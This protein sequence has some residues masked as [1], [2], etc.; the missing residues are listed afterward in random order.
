MSYETYRWGPNGITVDE[1]L[2][3]LRA[4]GW[5]VQD[6]RDY[7][8]GAPALERTWAR[9]PWR[10][11]DGADEHRPC[12]WCGHPGHLCLSYMPTAKCC[13]DYDHREVDGEGE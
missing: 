10:K 7:P 6:T 3:A 5:T 9:S 11:V 12:R 2:E 8:V 4:A 1:A 13:P